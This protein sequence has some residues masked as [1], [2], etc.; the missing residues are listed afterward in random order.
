MALIRPFIQFDKELVDIITKSLTKD[1]CRYVK[2][3]ACGLDGKKMTQIEIG[4][5]LNLTDQRV[6]QIYQKAIDKLRNDERFI[7]HIKQFNEAK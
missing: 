4:K 2:I 5:E 1:R 3:N 6:G 7:Y